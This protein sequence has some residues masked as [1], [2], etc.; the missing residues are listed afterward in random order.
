ML[1]YTCFSFLK[2]CFFGLDLNLHLNIISSQIQDNQVIHSFND[3]QEHQYHQILMSSSNGVNGHQQS[4]DITSNDSV[5]LDHHSRRN[6]Q[7]RFIDLPD[8]F[9]LIDSHCSKGDSVVEEDNSAIKLL[10]ESGQLQSQNF[11]YH[12][13][14]QCL[15]DNTEIIF[16]DEGSS[17]NGLDEHRPLKKR[18]LGRRDK[19][20]ATRVFPLATGNDN[21]FNSVVHQSTNTTSN[22]DEAVV[23]SE[24]QRELILELENRNAQLVLQQKLHSDL[25][26]NLYRIINCLVDKMASSSTGQPA[27][28]SSTA[29][30]ECMKFMIFV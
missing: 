17:T 27:F 2:K 9:Q 30:G 25:I 10:T 11:E 21:S 3:S 19:N 28:Q 1:F 20:N 13:D 12:D 8:G 24:S 16:C 29:I 15:T 18:R 4:E 7:L 23:S 22:F 6:E 5:V 14:Q 26:S